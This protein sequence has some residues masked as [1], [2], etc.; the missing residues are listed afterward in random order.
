M[1]IQKTE[2]EGVYIIDNFVAKD[3]RGIFVKTF[4]Q[5]KFKDNKLEFEIRESYF[6]ISQK[7]VI[8]GM[9]F[10]LPPNDHEKLVYV[11]QGAITDVVVDLRKK[12]DTYKK[13]IAVELSAENRRSIF[14]S[15]GLA[16][17]FKSMADN[18]IT[19]YNVATEYD[20]KSDQGIKYNSFGFD[21]QS[22]EAI[23][24]TRDKD[25]M[26]LD[27]FCEVNPF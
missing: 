12:S 15:K 21:W 9:H 3:E 2:L 17:G 19:V 5:Q 8:R 20:S 14:I 25:F 1:T 26:T 10:Q 22:N 4:N 27:Y 16:H 23:M 13:F 11:P 6:S 7:D 24:S 18:T